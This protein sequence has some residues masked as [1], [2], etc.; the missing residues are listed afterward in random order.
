MY[1]FVKLSVSIEKIKEI[2]MDFRFLII[3]LP[4]I[5]QKVH[6]NNSF[7]YDAP[8]LWND[9]P[10]DIYAVLQISHVSKVD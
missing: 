1:K 4:S 6:F 10:H 3:V 7:S 2:F 8:K 5:N 9:L